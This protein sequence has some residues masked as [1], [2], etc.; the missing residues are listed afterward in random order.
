MNRPNRLKPALMACAA[1]LSLLA[2]QPAF[3][4][5][6]DSAKLLELMV[7]KG[8][9]TREEADGLLAQATVAP[10]P[11]PIPAGGVAN[12]VQTIP[13]IPQV[14][15]DQIK[16]ELRAELSTQAQAQGWSA[17]GQTPEW[18][19]GIT[20]S[21][22]IR[23]RGEGVFMDDNNADIFVD[24]GAINAGGGQNI[25]DKTPGY[26]GP[27]YLNTLEDR[28]RARIRAR[29]GLKAQIDS[30]ISAE[31][32]VAT[33]N[34]TSPVST[35][36]TLGGGDEFGKYA[37]WLDRA[38]IRLTPVKDVALDFGRFANPFWTGDLIFD[39]DINFDGVAVSARHALNPAFA[40]FG[41]AGAFPIFNTDFNFGSRNAPEGK[42]GPFESR[43]KYLLAAQLGLDWT[44][45]DDMR[46]RAAVGYFNFDGVEGEVSSPCQFYEVACD[47]DPTRPQF[48]QF[49][50]TMFPIRNVVADPLNPIT[51]PENQYFGLA[52]AYEVL[53]VRASLDFNAFD[54]VGFRIEGDYV[55]NL[56]IDDAL[57]RLRAVNNLGPSTTIPD[58]TNTN[59][60]VTLPG[61]WD[62]GS[63]GWSLKLTAGRLD[64][65]S[66]GDWN[67]HAGYRRL[68]SDAVLDAFTDSD[69]HLGGTNSQGWMVGGAYA[70]GKNTAASARWLSGE[71][72]AGAPLSAD[73]LLIDLLTRF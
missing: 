4:Q 68:E 66:R 5:A 6:V 9:V 8:L 15:R 30:W 48:Q 20:L 16:E 40:V 27:P 44:P 51:S 3:A 26:V 7:A 54:G 21:G 46:V 14:V 35:N 56:G 36:Q 72:I 39:D 11:A 28:Q 13:Y 23:V 18:T 19:R 12:G 60:T 55:E 65:A 33:G 17:P 29:F 38:A 49:G 31:V 52:S 34:D 41:T 50:N 67:V 57:M 24:Y 45:R 10:T 63:S 73:R 61:V 47:T 1:G 32:R 25:N 42:G 62:G 71:E 70:I 43:D 69:F 59:G 64:L 37:L 2:A 22:D 58:P 53:N